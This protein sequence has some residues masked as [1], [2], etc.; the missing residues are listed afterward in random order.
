MLL[1]SL[2]LNAAGLAVFA[3]YTLVQALS[4]RLGRKSPPPQTGGAPQ[5]QEGT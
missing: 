2:P 5:R 1:D 4:G 3:A